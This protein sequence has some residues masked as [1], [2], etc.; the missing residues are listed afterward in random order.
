MFKGVKESVKGKIKEPK[1]IPPKVTIVEK[2][3]AAFVKILLTI[4]LPYNHHFHQ[5]CMNGLK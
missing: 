2:K 4:R 5:G 3:N 1:S